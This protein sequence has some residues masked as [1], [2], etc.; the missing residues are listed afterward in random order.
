MSRVRTSLFNLLSH[1]PRLA[2]TLSGSY[3]LD[4]CCGCGACGFEA[5][6]RGSAHVTFV[7]QSRAALNAV[8]ANAASL[9]LKEGKDYSVIR[10][11][12][13]HLVG[14]EFAH[15]AQ[16][17]YDICF[18]DPP[19][20]IA[21]DLIGR[22][23][24]SACELEWFGGDSLFICETEVRDAGSLVKAAL[25]ANDFSLLEQREYGRAALSVFRHF[26]QS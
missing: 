8:R 17:C 14:S 3:F 15:L 4:L 6:S 11:D 18:I 16:K 13:G 19:Y 26:R 20:P 2:S 7:D 5:I 24:T 9:N 1:S 25:M 22:V 10:A 21:I 12:V 23:I